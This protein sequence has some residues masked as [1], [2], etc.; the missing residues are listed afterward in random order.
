[1][2]RKFYVYVWIREDNNSVFYVGKGNGK[3]ARN[4]SMRN[5]HFKRIM[6]KTS[7]HYEIIC[8][9]LTED[10][11]FE[12][13]IQTIKYY[14]DLGYGIDIRG[15]EKTSEYYLVNSTLGGD[16]TSGYKHEEGAKSGEK[17]S[18]YGKTHT[19]ETREKIRQQHLG[20]HASEETKQKFSEMRKG[21]NNPMYG[22]RGENS[23]IYGTHRTE[24]EKMKQREALGTTV[25]CIELQ[26]RFPSLNYA[27]KYMKETYRIKLG[28]KTIKANCLGKTKKDWYGEIEIN[29]V[30]TKLHWTLEEINTYN[31]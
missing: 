12:L 4:T 30:L 27:E 29:G 23:P 11:A 13:E 14:L 22:K 5:Q 10:E 18:F 17:N 25:Y 31:D 15:Y 2:E 28:H 20:T 3:R 26:K 9:N 8:E 1:M 19:E 6:A 7:C 16:G 21:E 24:E